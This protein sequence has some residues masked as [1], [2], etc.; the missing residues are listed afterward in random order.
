MGTTSMREVPG[1]RRQSICLCMIVKNEALVIRRCLDSARPIIDHW[2]IVDTGSTDGTQD[3]IRAHFHDLPGTLYERPWC[4]F[5]TNRS[6]ALALARPNGDY[7]LVIDADD[8]L[9][10]PEDFA[11]PHL[12]ADSYTVDIDLGSTRYRRP[13]L[14]KNTL[15]WRYEG[16]LHEYL[17]CDDAATSGHLPLLLRINDD[18]ARRRDPLTYRQDAELLEKALETETALFRIA[19]YT[20][21]LAQ[22]YRDCGESE[23][24]LDTYLR[25]TKLGFWDQEIFVSFYVAAQLKE[26]MGEAPDAVLNLYEQASLVCPS[27][28][29]ARYRASRLCR[30]QNEF[31]RGYAIAKPAIDL[32]A[33]ADGLFVETWI[34][35]YGLLDEFAVNAYWAGHQRDC[36]D[37]VLR[38]LARGKIPSTEQQRFIENARFALAKLP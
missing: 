24:A 19:R 32:A 29:E 34:Y 12:D 21:Y 3:I 36:L 22:S 20:F 18:G 9:K 7:S 11:M 37:A 26:R 1:E 8:E 13:Q 10:I 6:E 33:P 23:K 17:A 35:D 5:A 30:L 25:R 27:R 15:P 4:D 28:A 16:V 38:A 2:I 31:A 14:L